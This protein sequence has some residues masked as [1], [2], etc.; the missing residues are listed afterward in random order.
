MRRNTLKLLAYACTIALGTT[1]VSNDVFAQAVNVPVTLGTSSTISVAWSADMDFGT[2]LLIHDG[3][4]GDIT[5]DLNPLTGAVV[6]TDGGTSFSAEVTASASV[7]TIDFSTPAAATV[8]VYGTITDFAGGSGLALTDPLYVLNST[9][10]AAALSVLVGA[11]TSMS[12]TGGADVL[13][14][15]ATV[16]VTASPADAGN[17]P[18]SID[19]TF[20]Y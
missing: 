11:P 13:E 8:Q 10:P 14:L 2:W 4:G 15:G 9:G 3:A 6:N 19:V 5:L 1:I 16:T 7:G 17:N 12:A 20:S 18:A